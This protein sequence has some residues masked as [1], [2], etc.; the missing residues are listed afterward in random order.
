MTELLKKNA[1]HWDES[2]QKA[3]EDLKAAM[4][5]APMLAL[6]DFTET[7]VV[8]TDAPRVGFGPMLM[9]EGYPIA[10]LSKALSPN[11]QSLSTY[12]K[13]LMAVVMAVDKWRSYLLGKHFIIRN[14]HFILK[15]IM[16]Q[17]ITTPFKAM[18]TQIDGF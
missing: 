2:T 5:S 4:L 1:F 8:E 6:P 9:Q 12:E 18:V 16:E 15:Y 11:H 17:K 14:D 7:F 13:Q 3:F 10:Y